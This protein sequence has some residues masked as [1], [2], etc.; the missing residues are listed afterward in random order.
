MDDIK[1]RLTRYSITEPFF[2][3]YP[4]VGEI[5]GHGTYTSVY[6]MHSKNDKVAVVKVIP[7]SIYKTDDKYKEIIKKFD[8]EFSRL[9]KIKGQLL[10]IP[11]KYEIRSWPDGNGTDILILM[12]FYELNLKTELNNYNFDFSEEN[13]IDTGLRLCEAVEILHR[14]KVTHGN[15]KPENI[16][17][18]HSKESD[19]SKYILADFV[20]TQPEHVSIKSQ[21]AINA[22]SKYAAPEIFLREKHKSSDIYSIGI[23]LYQLMNNNL[24][25]FELEIAEDKKAQIKEAITRRKD[26]EEIPAPHHCD[27]YSTL[28]DII[29]KACAYKKEKRYKSIKKLKASL[30]GAKKGKEKVPRGDIIRAIAA[31]LLLILVLAGSIYFFVVIWPTV[32]N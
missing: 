22:T 7:L 12:E 19:E 14:Q 2:K 5:I 32:P 30:K 17:I 29:L 23:L 1:E 26:G 15:I 3:E 16:F 10:L 18:F 31:G 11:L 24:V 28:S 9:E 27:K 21:E 25:P 4:M 20:I 8:N 13:I 6:K